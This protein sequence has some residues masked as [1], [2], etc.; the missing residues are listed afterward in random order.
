[1]HDCTFQA[2]AILSYSCHKCEHFSPPPHMH[3]HTLL[4]ASVSNRQSCIHP[5][6]SEYIGPKRSLHRQQIRGGF[7]RKVKMPSS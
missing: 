4:H 5:M 6:G 7:E 3:T 2:V 1:M